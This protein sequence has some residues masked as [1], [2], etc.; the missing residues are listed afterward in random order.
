MTA[1]FSVFFFNDRLNNM[2]TKSSHPRPML[3]NIPNTTSSLPPLE[4]SWMHAYYRQSRYW[5]KKSEF[6]WWVN[7]LLIFFPLLKGAGV[8]VFV[9]TKVFGG[10]R[11]STA[12]AWHLGR[13]WRLRK[14]KVLLDKQGGTHF[15]TLQTGHF[16]FRCGLQRL[17]DSRRFYTMPSV[18]QCK[19]DIIHDFM[20]SDIVSVLCVEEWSQH[21]SVQLLNKIS[22]RFIFFPFN[23]KLLNKDFRRLA[24]LLYVQNSETNQQ[25]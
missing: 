11:K 16:V 1:S 15:V 3:F 17:I 12:Y 8:V 2:H 5:T 20:N 14:R 4:A 22:Q 13:L 6:L 24:A 7:I 25:T 9:K 10:Q 23:Q 18:G 19:A 21:C